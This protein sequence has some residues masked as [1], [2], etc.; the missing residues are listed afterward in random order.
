MRHR[1]LL[2][3]CVWL[4]PSGCDEEKNPVNN[5]GPEVGELGGAC[6]GDGT[7]NTDDLVCVADVCEAAVDPCAGVDCGEAGQCR[8]SPF[9]QGQTECVCL[10]GAFVTLDEACSYGDPLGTREFFAQEL[11]QD[12]ETRFYYMYVPSGYDHGSA[13]ALLVD[14][15]GTAGDQPELAYG[16]EAA[17]AAAEAYGF[18]LVRP[19]S[20]SS[21]E[22]GAAIYRWDQNNGDTER[23]H[24]FVAA[25]VTAVSRRVNL[26]PERLYLMGFS[27]GTNQTARALADGAT[28]FSGFGFVGGGLWITNALQNHGRAYLA[29]GFR[30]YM[31]T[32]HYNL[33]GR[34]DSIGF[35]PER[36]FNREFDGGHEL[37]GYFY[38]EMFDFF[39]N[40]KRPGTGTPV[41][42]W[43][44]ETFPDTTSLVTATMAPDG[45]VFAAGTGNGLARRLGPD[46]WEKVTI[47]GASAF[48]GRTVTELCF[49]E[50]GTGLAIGEG[51][52]IRSE[53]DG[54]TWTHG[55]KI[56]EVDGPYFGYQFLNGAACAGDAMVATGYW[57]GARSTDGGLTWSDLAFDASYGQRAQGA[58]VSAAPW[59]TWTAGGY[60]QY[61]GRSEDGVTFAPAL[62]PGSAMADWYYD[63]APVRPDRWVAVGDFGTILVSDDDGASYSCVICD[64]A[65]ENLYAVGFAGDNG[66]AVGGHG[67]ALLTRD[68]GATWEDVATGLDAYLGD[69]VWL[70]AS[71]AL[72]VGEAGTVLRISVNP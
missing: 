41:P 18:I 68:G 40:G 6:H 66:L 15:H 3:L 37:Y 2:L 53:D 50:D 29:T 38:P 57:Q 70:S 24:A 59:G 48:P 27:S 71:E 54:A 30:D 8:P 43:V 28:R 7:C 69:V 47:A 44:R 33:T 23:N 11:Q 52:V 19:R 42:P 32:Y 49:T 51:Q 39:D 45:T 21:E 16:L 63:L 65:G 22:G 12:L 35:A 17:K 67:A 64:G 20:R 46:S 31:R 1:W 58:V 13:A 9:D 25:L 4:I 34:L 55:P 10:E 14:L 36:R 72:V 62:L 5:T 56:G 61:L 26:D 60:W